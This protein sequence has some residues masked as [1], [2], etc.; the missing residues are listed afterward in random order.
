M[1]AETFNGLMK[2]VPRLTLRQRELFRK[3][4]DE[5]DAQLAKVWPSLSHKARPRHVA[6]RNAMAPPFTCMA[7]SVDCSAIAAKHAAA[8]STH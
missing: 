8:P 3:R 4:L 1:N 6:V 2:Q 5:L 7:R